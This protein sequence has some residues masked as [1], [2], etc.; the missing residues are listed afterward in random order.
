MPDSL[1]SRPP[2]PLPAGRT[3]L[4]GLATA[5]VWIGL[6]IA[7]IRGTADLS[8]M[9][10]VVSLG[11]PLAF[12]ALAVFLA[13]TLASL[14]Q[15]AQELRAE[16]EHIRAAQ[17][18]GQTGVAQ[19]E[20]PTQAPE[21]SQELA[22]PFTS[23]APTAHDAFEDAPVQF[24][25]KRHAPVGQAQTAIAQ[26]DAQ[27]SLALK[28]DPL[29]PPLQMEDLIRALHFPETA[30]D[31]EGFRAMRRAL[32]DH[33]AGQVIQASQDVLTLLSQ[34]GIYMDDL[35]PD[36]AHPELWRRFAQGERGGAMSPV[37]GVR[38]ADLLDTCG[39]RMREDAVFRD[40]AHHFLRRFD[41]LLT[42]IEPDLSDQDI[43]YLTDTRTARAFMLLGRTIGLFE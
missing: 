8:G 27:G 28:S 36:R 6:W 41:R 43:A 39:T 26:G 37:G 22:D 3:I 25:S 42:E 5:L 35:A 17:M 31:V 30:E 1:A 32:R 40:V 34:S 18:V 23:V 19:V 14:R 10:S 12:I 9:A 29:P 24:T 7:F 11:L 38:D 33:R 20:K 4:F 21:T 15:Q 13:L 2:Q 16:I